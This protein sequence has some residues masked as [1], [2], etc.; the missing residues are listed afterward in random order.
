MRDLQKIFWDCMG[1]MDEIGIDYGNIVGVKVNTRAKK[2][3]GQCCRKFVG[4]DAYG[5][6]KYEH[7]ID[8]SEIL[9]DE[10]V[11][12]ESL[13]NT[14]IHEILHTCPGCSNHG[15]EWK[16]RAEKVKKELG[17]NIKRC[18]GNQEKGISDAV[19]KEYVKVKYA[20]RCK[21]CGREVGKLRMCGVIK[22]PQNWRCGVCGGEF[23][24]IM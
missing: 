6:P 15:P 9:L 24:R 20:V 23:E 5:N 3:W 2:R 17:Y 14:I 22:Y 19:N 12:L 13:Q 1:M 11:P 10:R 8:I 16:K 7:T 4:R 21:K 18:S